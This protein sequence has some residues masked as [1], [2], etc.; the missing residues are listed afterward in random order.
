MA[1]VLGAVAG[2]GIFNKN[3]RNSL[4]GKSGKMKQLS[5]LTP[6]QQ[7]LMSLLTEGLSTGEGPLS[8]LF[9]S[10]NKASFD[11]GV[12]KPQLKQFQ[13][14]ILPILQ[15]KFIAGNQVGGSGM[16]RA[17]MRAATDLQSKLAAL[18]YAAQQNQQQN[19]LA[20]LQAGLGTRAMENVY[21]PGK[22]GLL[23]GFLQGA[24]QSAGKAIGSYIAG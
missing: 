20:G 9:G 14:E 10:F 16:Q 11:E 17:Q 6:E 1:N 19:R 24:G 12:V 23:G 13:E 2:G 4:F 22:Q 18:T 5:N 8:D 15:E 7:Q 21:Q 3:F